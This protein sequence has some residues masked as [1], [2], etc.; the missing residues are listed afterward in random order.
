MLTPAA[1]WLTVDNPARAASPPP[2][3]RVVEAASGM[4]RLTWGPVAN[5]SYYKVE[6]KSAAGK[7]STVRSD[8]PE[9]QVGSLASD[10]RYGI[11]VRAVLAKGPDSRQTPFSTP[12]TAKTK[13][14]SQP[15]LLT[16]EWFKAST[17]DPG[18][19]DASWEPIAGASG[20]ELQY[21]DNADFKDARTV[22]ADKSTAKVT[23]LD[24]GRQVHLRVRSIGS[25]GEF[26][27]WATP[28]TATTTV[29]DSDPVRAASYNIVCHSCGKAPWSSRRI[30]V[31]SLIA[32][33]N[34][35]V[36][37]VQEAQQSRPRG[38]NLSQ[39][40]DLVRALA[41]TGAD[42]RVTDR[43]IGASKGTRILYK[44]STMTLLKTGAIRYASQRRG[45]TDRYAAWAIFRQR[46]TGR[47]MAFFSTHLEP[48]SYSVRLA[49]S[50]QLAA[51][52]AS[53]A[54]KRPVVAV[55]DFNASQFHYYAVHQAMTGAGLVDP[56]GVQQK[57]KVPAKNAT[58]E[59][60]INTNFDSYNGYRRRASVGT[61]NPEGNGVYI[62]YIFTSPMR[63]VEYEQVV[64]IDG[65]GNFRGVIPSDHN[66]LRADVVLPD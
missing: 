65:N 10:A 43:A 62:D 60:R 44:P 57:S 46:S 48:K 19:V 29:P 56:L 36:V 25:K 47:E 42:Y 31:A 30:P 51:S 66:M 27:A 2:N 41:Q 15:R 22:K 23:K 8:G 39:F 61:S 9:V 37:G 20:Y 1:I 54:G 14:D 53:I 6:L 45:A 34:P 26:S 64:R 24:G 35:D 12:I 17:P 21:A 4:L 5:T 18:E 13:A 3:T 7:V 33:Q 16:S 52:I 32:E 63:V 50:R 59:K 49:Q 40:D 58:V 28:I 55:G 11:R 38:F